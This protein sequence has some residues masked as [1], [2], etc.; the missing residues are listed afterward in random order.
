[1]NCEWRDGAARVVL[2]LCGGLSAGKDGNS[3]MDELWIRPEN[4]GG[5][6]YFSGK[7]Y[8]WEICW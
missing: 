7:L 3:G 6:R 5:A 4:P 1:M 2:G 8:I